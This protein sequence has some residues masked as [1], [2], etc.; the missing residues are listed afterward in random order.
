MTD[1]NV[2][3]NVIINSKIN[4]PSRKFSDSVN[5]AMGGSKGS[6]KDFSGSVSNEETETKIDLGEK[7]LDI[8]NLIMPRT[9]V[10]A[11]LSVGQ[12]A[13]SIVRSMA[14]IVPILLGVLFG[15]RIMNWIRDKLSKPDTLADDTI[16]PDEYHNKFRHGVNINPD[17][18]G[19]GIGDGGGSTE[20]TIRVEG[21]PDS[22][23]SI[24]VE[25]EMRLPNEQ[26]EELNA[27]ITEPDK[28]LE[29]DALE[30]GEGYDSIFGD[31]GIDDSSEIGKESS[32]ISSFDWL[33]RDMTQDVV[34]IQNNQSKENE[35]VE[36]SIEFEL[37]L[38]TS[39]FDESLS[40]IKTD[41]S[42]LEPIRRFDSA[43]SESISMETKGVETLVAG[44][45]RSLNNVLD[46]IVSKMNQIKGLRGDLDSATRV[47]DVEERQ[48]R[49]GNLFGN[50]MN[51]IGTIFNINRNPS[52]NDP[53]LISSPQQTE[54]GTATEGMTDG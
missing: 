4:K 54:K 49:I 2:E 5:N 34:N 15:P 41:E 46:E 18:F 51:A 42:L 12:V 1:K 22:D 26:I 29:E 52:G 47:A 27:S 17:D 44:P 31:M 10:T 7:I 23:F 9:L 45:Y 38:D 16:D 13:Q 21:M 53:G 35:K 3:L 32:G 28:I 14:I 19:S 30:F 37:D 6:K 40:K 39:R 48:T 8:L 25:E 36:Q 50:T 20:G 43:L 24:S 11:L 33:N